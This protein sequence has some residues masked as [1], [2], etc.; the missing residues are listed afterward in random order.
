MPASALSLCL[1]EFRFPCAFVPV[2]GHAD[3]T[4]L[5]RYVWTIT[6]TASNSGLLV[7]SIGYVLLCFLYMFFFFFSRGLDVITACGFSFYFVSPTGLMAMVAI[8]HFTECILRQTHLPR[9]AFQYPTP[10]RR[11]GKFSS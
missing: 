3:S 4:L 11:R 9:H 1:L 8:A 6:E 10:S 7:H 2:T 5:F